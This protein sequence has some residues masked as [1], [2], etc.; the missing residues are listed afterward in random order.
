MLFHFPSGHNINWFVRLRPIRF[1]RV[2]KENG[3]NGP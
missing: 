1:R 2:P 3:P